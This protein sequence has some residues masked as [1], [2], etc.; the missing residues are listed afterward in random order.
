[1]NYKSI[2]CH[3]SRVDWTPVKI[4]LIIDRPGKYTMLLVLTCMSRDERERNPGNKMSFLSKR[5]LLLKHARRTERCW[6]EMSILLRI[7]SYS[8][9]SYDKTGTFDE[10]SA[11]A[12]G[13]ARKTYVKEKERKRQENNRRD[14]LIQKDVDVRSN[15]SSECKRS[16]KVI[17]ER[18]NAPFPSRSYRISLM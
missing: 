11:W 14:R 16:K 5:D 10:N 2:I 4:S 8:H 15:E 6:A 13:R 3:I 7:A 17:I 9:E 18:E 12:A 1:M